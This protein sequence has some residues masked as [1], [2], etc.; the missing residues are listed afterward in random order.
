MNRALHA[1]TIFAALLF[2]GVSATM[3]ALFL[4][5]LGRTML[6]VGLLAAV[7][8]ASDISKGGAS[9]LDGAGG[10]ATRLGQCRRRCAAV[11]RRYGTVTGIGDGICC[12]DARR[13]NVDAAGPLRTDCSHPSGAARNRNA[14]RSV[15]GFA[16]RRY[17]RSGHCCASHRSAL[18]N[19]NILRRTN[20]RFGP[21]ILRG[22]FTASGGARSG[23]RPRQFDR[24]AA[25]ET[26]RT[27]S[28]TNQLG[29][30][31]MTTHKR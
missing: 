21:S 4:S 23:T 16:W 2:L 24:C 1:L 28:T 10:M 6:E 14:S 19:V 20:Y 22:G 25:D 29:S 18:A 7:S 13:D 31:L 30:L 8:L 3:N 17:H 9:G 11:D 26:T 5:S 12:A 15:D 27:R